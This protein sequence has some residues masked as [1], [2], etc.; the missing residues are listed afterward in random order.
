M[1]SPVRWNRTPGEPD[2]RDAREGIAGCEL[3][4]DSLTGFRTVERRRF[5]A[6]PHP[7]TQD[8]DFMEFTETIELV[9]RT[10]EGAGWLSSWSGTSSRP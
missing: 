5:P 7:A 10:I 1:R 8:S 6:L 2:Q 3:W 4:H 9:G